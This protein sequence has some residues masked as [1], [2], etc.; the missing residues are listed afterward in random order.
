M[1]IHA[2]PPPQRPVFLPARPEY[3]AQFA[4]APICVIHGLNREPQHCSQ[5]R[6]Y[7]VWYWSYGYLLGS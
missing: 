1:H 7:Q 3:Q 2:R 5:C 6:A 4:A